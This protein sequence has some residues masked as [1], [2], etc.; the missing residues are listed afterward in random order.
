[1]FC[2]SRQNYI[3]PIYLSIAG[4]VGFISLVIRPIYT[5]P[6]H[7]PTAIVVLALMA[8]LYF[9]RESDTLA[10]IG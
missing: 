8:R 6:T 2:L 1:V 5:R 4:D 7:R 3:G 9:I 10:V